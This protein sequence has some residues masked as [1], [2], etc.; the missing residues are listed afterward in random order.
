MASAHDGNTG[1][2]SL[3]EKVERLLSKDGAFHFGRNFTGFSQSD[4]DQVV[5][6]NKYFRC[7]LS[8]APVSTMNERGCLRDDLAPGVWLKYFQSHVLP[9][10]NRFNLPSE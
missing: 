10:L 7:E 2:Q 3:A 9:T 8:K 1:Q 5:S 6:L 4:A